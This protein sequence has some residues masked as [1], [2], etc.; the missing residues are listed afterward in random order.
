MARVE[1]DK[2]RLGYSELTDSIYAY[3]PSKTDPDKMLHKV[4]VH[5]DFNKLRGYLNSKDREKALGRNENG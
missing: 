3:I 5:S 1:I 2:I 4:N